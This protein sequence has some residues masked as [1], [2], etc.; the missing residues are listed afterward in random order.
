MDYQKACWG[1]RKAEEVRDV[2]RGLWSIVGVLVCVYIGLSLLY[3]LPLAADGHIA[4][5][6]RWLTWPWHILKIF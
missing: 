2:R 3:A 1:K 4:D 6:P 5:V